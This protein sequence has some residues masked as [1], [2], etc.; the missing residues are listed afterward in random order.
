MTEFW[1]EFLDRINK[2]YRIRD[3]YSEDVS[4]ASLS[5]ETFDMKKEFKIHVLQVPSV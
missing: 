4:F 1:A 5:R 2:I 3:G